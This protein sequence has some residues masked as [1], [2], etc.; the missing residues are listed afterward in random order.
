M[1]AVD[2]YGQT[3][4][5]QAFVQKTAGPL[6]VRA[7]PEEIRYPP[8]AGVSCA[9]FAGGRW[10]FEKCRERP[11]MVTIDG[12]LAALLGRQDLGERNNVCL[13]VGGPELEVGQ[14]LRVA[15][16]SMSDAKLAALMWVGGMDSLMDLIRDKADFDWHRPLL[17]SSSYSLMLTIF[18]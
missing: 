17:S 11:D 13:V 3:D 12:L 16:E 4:I 6:G 5:E 1:K 2:H 8:V 18:V 14:E 15:F 9:G 10:G 7:F